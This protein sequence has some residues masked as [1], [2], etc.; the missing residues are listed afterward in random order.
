MYENNIIIIVIFGHQFES[1]SLQKFKT[2]SVTDKIT[3]DSNIDCVYCIQLFIDRKI[4][5]F[6]KNKEKPGEKPFRPV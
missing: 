2:R 1:F 4:W 6:S 5:I 3:I